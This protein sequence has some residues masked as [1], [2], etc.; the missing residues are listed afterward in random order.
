MTIIPIKTR[1]QKR[2]L[3]TQQHIHLQTQNIQ[4][5][6]QC[7]RSI[8]RN[9]KTIQRNKPKPNTKTIKQRNKTQK[10]NLQHPQI[11][12]TTKKIGFLQSQ[13]NMKK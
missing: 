5:K 10:P 8:Q 4:T 11:N 3:Q 7:R 2:T 13:K 9:Q 12:T 1:S 6:K